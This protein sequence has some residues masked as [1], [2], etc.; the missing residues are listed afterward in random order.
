MKAFAHHV[1]YE[2][3]SGFRDK[4]QL[5]MNY[6][7]PIVFFALV[8]GLM[9]KVNPLFTKTM[10]AAMTI[11][12]LMSSSLL[13]LPSALVTARESGLLRSYRI[14]GVPAWAAL[15]APSLANIVHMAIVTAFF[16]IAGKLAFG[17]PLPSS[18]P[19]FVLAWLLVTAAI[20][21]LGTLIGAISNSGRAAILV[22]QLFFIPSIMLGGLMMPP[23][24]LPPGLAAASK[25]FP[26]THAMIAF[27]GG[28]GGPGVESAGLALAVLAIGA[29]ASI[30]AAMV[31]YEWDPKNERPPARK[32][33]GLVAL[34]PYVAALF[35]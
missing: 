19:S 3:R 26:A 7:F 34:A 16:A 15:A 23:D 20:S 5:L 18:W 9:S 2:F 27:A 33:L 11:F 22:S 17:A 8:G 1:V 6:L 29:L 12:A 14:N 25:L 35:I 10:L 30:A 4:S 31:L 32:L 24:I 28:R 21:G 13:S